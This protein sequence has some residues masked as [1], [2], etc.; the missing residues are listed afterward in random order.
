MTVARVKA[1]QAEAAHQSAMKRS[2]LKKDARQLKK[3]MLDDAKERERLFW[4]SEEQALREHLIAAHGSHDQK[5]F[6]EKANLLLDRSRL[7]YARML[8]EREVSEDEA[9]MD[10]YL[11]ESILESAAKM[12]TEASA[13]D[14]LFAKE[15][16]RIENMR[17][18]HR[19]QVQKLKVQNKKYR[20]NL[21][22]TQSK[23]LSDLL[24]EQEQDLKKMMEQQD[25]EL[26]ALIESQD[27]LNANDQ[28][29]KIANDRMSISL[30][31][32][33]VD[34]LKENKSIEP[35]KFQNLVFLSADIVN[36]SSVSSEGTP[37]QVI[38]TLTTLYSAMDE[39]IGSFTDV[40]KM[41]TFGRGAI[42]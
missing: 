33:V 38:G 27:V 22:K 31:S 2:K 4:A 5:R 42:F 41:E 32:Y 24:E 9:D 12:V 39:I 7:H 19:D 18:I 16:F 3:K 11:D 15:M 36:L 37:Q 20:E 28:E 23:A 1:H 34:T 8:L 6:E 26:R 25:K 10:D 14:K 40:Y 17:K 35:N 30:P 13:F 21:K 29:S